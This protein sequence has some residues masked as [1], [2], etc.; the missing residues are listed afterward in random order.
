M[1]LRELANEIAKTV[2]CNCDLDNWEPLQDT[3]HSY[4]CDIRKIALARYRR[5]RN[6]G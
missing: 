5:E 6:L 1:S 3:G 2:Q 4:V